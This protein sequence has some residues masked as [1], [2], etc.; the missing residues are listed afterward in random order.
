VAQ[1]SSVAAR[2]DE[3]A[4]IPADEAK[5]LRTYEIYPSLPQGMRVPGH[6]YEVVV[7]VCVAADGHVSDVV[8]KHGAT[9]ELDRLLASAMRSWRYRV[10]MANG[11]ARPFCHLMKVIYTFG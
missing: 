9:A 11:V 8:I 5:Y 2:A 7:E 6:V 3:S 1:D 4:E 10:L